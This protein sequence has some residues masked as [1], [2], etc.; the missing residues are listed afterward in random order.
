ML[1]SKYSL[2]KISPLL[3]KSIPEF[4]KN[5]VSGRI[6]IATITKSTSTFFPLS[7]KMLS[8]FFSSNFTT[9]SRSEEHTSELQSRQYLVCRLL[10][11]KKKT[12]PGRLHLLY[13]CYR[14][15]DL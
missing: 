4:C 1:V 11:E 14:S 7:K 13:S 3:P 2:T 10:L 15:P 8:P 5:L 6:P 9:F 12:L